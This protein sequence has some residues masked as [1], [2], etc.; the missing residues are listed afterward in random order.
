MKVQ[1][2][3]ETTVQK[4]KSLL[5]NTLDNT[6]AG[7]QF[8]TLLKQHSHSS[9]NHDTDAYVSGPDG[10]L[11]PLGKLTQGNNSVAK[12][13]LSHPELKSS[14]WSIVHNAVNKDKPYQQIPEGTA[15]YYNPRTHELHWQTEP[16]S[17]PSETRNN[18]SGISNKQAKLQPYSSINSDQT[19]NQINLGQLNATNPTVAHLLMQHNDFK[20]TRWQIIHSDINKDK[21]YTRIPDGSSIFINARTHE[22]SWSTPENPSQ[23][24]LAQET[25]SL[26]E[27][28]LMLSRKLDE[29]VKPYMGKAYKDIDCYTLVV[30]GLKNL[31]V[32]YRG[33]GS[34]S[35][36][37]LNM[38]QT[39]G[40]ALNAYFTGE[41]ITQAMGKKIYTRAIN[42]VED[43]SRQSQTIYQEMKKLMQKG[44]LLSF[45]LET[46]GHTGVISQNQ[47]QWTYIN[48]GRL[49]NSIRDNAPRHGVGEESL[50]EEISN[51]I[52]LAQKRNESLQITVGRLN[53][54]KF[55]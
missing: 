42:R 36:E 22:L 11:M 13:L 34:L 41:G 33:Q 20:A 37:L 23:V 30:N 31:G 3:I 47:D 43:I 46:K 40:R 51:W 49:D 35:R 4:Q 14:T 10:N 32:K 12:L 50:L 5:N 6:L 38:A 24:K 28:A 53:H 55:A 27:K 26:S 9:H 54:E 2:I 19:V 39:E 17:Q 44:D 29:A 7:S 52:K 1:N 45:S 16:G 15:I 18:L 8:T 21:A 48:S 25:G